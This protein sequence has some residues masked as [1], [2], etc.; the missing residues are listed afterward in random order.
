MGQATIQKDVAPLF[1]TP[2]AEAARTD[3]G[4]YGMSVQVL[5]ESENGWCFVRTDYGTQGYMPSPCL[6]LS[7][8]VAVSW[9]KYPKSTVLA[10]Y[11]DIQNRPAGNAATLLSVPRG[12][13]LVALKNPDLNGWQKVGL[14][15]GSIG[16]TRA[17]YL[18]EVIEDWTQ[19]S[20]NDMR[21]NL[22]ESALSYNGTAY[23]EGGGSPLGIDAVG[24]VAMAYLLNGVVI[25]RDLVFKQG[26]PLHRIKPDEMEEGDLIYFRDSVGMFM[27]DGHFVHA[28]ELAGNEGVVVSSLRPRDEDYRPDLAEHIVGVASLF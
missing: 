11:I 7:A 18:G 28:T 15:N 27:G 1:E 8:E 14:A 16:Y 26:S 13:L 6:N 3:E 21:W 20:E 2:S 24:L 22:V 10:P 12:S 23:R 25:P 9:K 4:L 5:E 17:S 19:L